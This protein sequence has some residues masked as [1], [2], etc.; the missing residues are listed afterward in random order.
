[1]SLPSIDRRKLQVLEYVGVGLCAASY[2]MLFSCI[3][4]VLVSLCV[5]RGQHLRF[6][7]DYVPYV[8][9]QTAKIDTVAIHSHLHNIYT[10]NSAVGCKHHRDMAHRRYLAI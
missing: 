3:V 5:Q 4:Y 2:G 8:A 9:R 1:M 10:S 6:Q 7:L